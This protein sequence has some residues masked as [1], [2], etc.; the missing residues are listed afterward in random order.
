[1]NEKRAKLARRLARQAALQSETVYLINTKTGVIRLGKCEKG[2]YRLIKNRWP[3]PA[4]YRLQQAAAAKAIRIA[5]LSAN[6]AE[7]ACSV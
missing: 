3:S 4:E 6:T 1:M 5:A 7:V 2:V